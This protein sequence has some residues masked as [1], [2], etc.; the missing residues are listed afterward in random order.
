MSGCGE[1]K[2]DDPAASESFPITEAALVRK[3]DWRIV[4]TLFL[5]Y[6][7]QFLDKVAINTATAFFIGYVVA[8]WPQGVLLRHFPISKVLGCNIFA[9]GIT[10]CCSAACH[11]TPSII[12]V[13]TLLG[14]C[15]AV[16][17]PALIVFTSRWYT[18]TEAPL[19]YGI[20]YCGLGAGQIVG[21]LISFGAQ[22][23]SSVFTGWRVM[24][25][26]IGVFN[27]LVAL[28]I[29][30]TLP[31]NPGEAQF[32]GQNEKELLEERL[33]WDESRPKPEELGLHLLRE[34]LLDPQTW[35]LVLLTLCITI[36]S[37]VITTFSATLIHSF[38]YNSKQS[39][40]LN[41]K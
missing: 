8:E 36:P 1:T 4:P 39:A 25:I 7:L 27:I 17:A 5:A 15:E 29:L 14:V 12:A 24:F 38:G 19:R 9:W 35:L 26:C 31:D 18:K 41:V 40:L 16:I 20:W 28:L 13:R 2:V 37:G 33:G 21:G 22:H 30:F 32:L 10:L 11:D 34:L 23:S 3:I 6:F